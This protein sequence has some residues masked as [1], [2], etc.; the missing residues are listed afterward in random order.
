MKTLF[1]LPLFVFS[2]LL[3]AQVA[4]MRSIPSDS[5]V[6]VE[7]PRIGFSKIGDTISIY[8]K[9][10]NEWGIESGHNFTGVITKIAL[11]DE[12]QEA[13]ITTTAGEDFFVSDYRIGLFEIGDTIKIYKRKTITDDKKL[14]WLVYTGGLPPGNYGTMIIRIGIVK[15]RWR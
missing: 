3:S 1:F 15:K 5:I 14:D 6:I 11:P 4:I 9:Q 8:N 12:W 10:T 2:L 13:K 7:D